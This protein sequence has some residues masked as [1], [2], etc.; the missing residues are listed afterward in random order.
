MED[1]SSSG[2]ADRTT[3]WPATESRGRSDCRRAVSRA[4]HLVGLIRPGCRGTV[5]P[6]AGARPGPRAASGASPV[7]CVAEP[8]RA[9]KRP[10]LR[11]CGAFDEANRLPPKRTRTSPPWLAKCSSNCCTNAGQF[12][13]PTRLLQTRVS[14]NSHASLCRSHCSA[15]PQQGCVIDDVFWPAA[16]S[17]SAYRLRPI[18]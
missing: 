17:R 18:T 13:T 8:G 15:S 4:E 11:N 7:R 16:D 6:P 2:R 14:R 12:P 1:S 5:P 10:R 9:G 3:P